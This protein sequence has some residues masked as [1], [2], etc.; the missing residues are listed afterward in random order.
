MDKLTKINTFLKRHY[1]DPLH[2]ECYHLV[3][4]I[5]DIYI[6]G[7]I[8]DSDTL[9]APSSSRSLDDIGV[10]LTTI[11]KY[12]YCIGN[13][14]EM[15]KYYM[16]AIEKGNTDA[17]FN[18]G[19]CGDND[20]LIVKYYMMAVE[21]GNS[22]A[23][24][25]IGA[26]YEHKHNYSEMKK[27]YT[28]AI[29]RGNPYA[30][31]QL[32]CY[33]NLERDYDNMKRYYLMA[34]EKGHTGAMYCLGSKEELIKHGSGLKYFMMGIAK[35]DTSCMIRVAEYYRDIGDN[36]EMEK[37]YMMAAETGFAN[38]YVMFT[39]ITYYE[40]KKKYECAIK[41]C[42][43]SIGTTEESIVSHMIIKYLTHEY[44]SIV[45]KYLIEL[46]MDIRTLADY[47]VR[48]DDIYIKLHDI[49]KENAMLKNEVLELQLRPPE[50]R[51]R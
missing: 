22:D 40:T 30:M 26:Y 10:L 44:I 4:D 32:G 15:K 38:D 18:M 2:E 7:H 39:I 14:D 19:Y 34:I 12:Y 37:Y 49:T 16:L 42:L 48:F 27:Y 6:N 1:L 25:G 3:D 28:M 23:M 46:D 8:I 13:R 33:Y 45:I 21:K 20:E 51:G 35:G 5:Y 29:E 17:M 9:T 47:Y 31:F 36:V 11:G 24:G 50:L 43:L 41:C